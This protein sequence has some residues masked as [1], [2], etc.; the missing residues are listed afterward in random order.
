MPAP[1]GQRPNA[2][3]PSPIG[4]IPTIT[5]A[6]TPRSQANRPPAASP[7]SQG[8][9]TRARHGQWVLDRDQAGVA[10][11]GVAPVG[12]LRMN[13][14]MSRAVRSGWSRIT[15]VRLSGMVSSWAP[16]TIAASRSPCA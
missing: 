6:E 16:G 13:S 14:L 2:E 11:A 3:Q 4:C 8:T 15:Q 7:T 12:V 5:T 1:T 9:T 10:S